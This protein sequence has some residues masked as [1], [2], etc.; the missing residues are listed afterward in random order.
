MSD[1]FG[2]YL[3]EPVPEV[4]IDRKNEL[5]TEEDLNY[6]K[7]NEP[8]TMK[9]LITFAKFVKG[10]A[11]VISGSVLMVTGAKLVVVYTQFIWGLW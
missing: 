9:D 1:I 11:L 4:G 10:L 2:Q 3:N 7:R 8:E 6:V 5:I